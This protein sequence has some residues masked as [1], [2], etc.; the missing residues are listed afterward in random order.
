MKM[1]IEILIRLYE[2]KKIQA[3]MKM[4]LYVDANLY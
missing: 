4:I 2:K 1:L 3:I